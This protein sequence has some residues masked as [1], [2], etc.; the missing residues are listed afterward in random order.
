MINRLFGL[1]SRNIAT[2]KLTQKI[3]NTENSKN[4]KSNC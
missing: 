1:F 3:L 2:I 4:I